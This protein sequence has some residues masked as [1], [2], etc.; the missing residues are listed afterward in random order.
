MNSR[1]DRMSKTLE[2]LGYEK[3]ENEEEIDFVNG[4][5]EILFDKQKKEFAGEWFI[6]DVRF[7]VPVFSMEE[8]KAIY[9]YCEDLGWI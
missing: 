3:R 9:K 2:E 7:V 4:D 5:K 8:L 1:R 6:P